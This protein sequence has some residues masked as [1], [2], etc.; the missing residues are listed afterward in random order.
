M[1]SSGLVLPFA[2][3]AREGQLTSKVPTPELSRLTWPEPSKREPSQCVLAVRVVP[4]PCSFAVLS[5]RPDGTPA[6]VEA[7]APASPAVP[8]T[9]SGPP[10]ETGDRSA[11][12]ERRVV[13][14]LLRQPRARGHV[15]GD[16]LEPL[17]GLH[18]GAYAGN[19]LLEGGHH[20]L[21]P[22]HDDRD[23]APDAALG[24]RDE[25]LERAPADLLVG[26]GQLAADG[27]A[28]V[29]AEGVP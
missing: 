20:A 23:L 9:A 29:G 1:S 13:E 4:M 14:R 10:V 11:S 7:T 19:G 22:R 16:V 17:A 26:L 25:V 3:S 15:G 18:P 28:P 8:A 27:R 12:G 5:A 21:G 24:P 2:D 6:V